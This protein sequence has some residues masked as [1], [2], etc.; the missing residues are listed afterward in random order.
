MNPEKGEP[1]MF[2]NFP[3][4]DSASVGVLEEVG[5]EGRGMKRAWWE[6]NRGSGNTRR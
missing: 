2:I 3:V 5:G 6:A 1:S 4:G